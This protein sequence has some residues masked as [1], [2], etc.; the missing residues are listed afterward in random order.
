MKRKFLQ[1]Y[2]TRTNWNDTC[3]STTFLHNGL[4]FVWDEAQPEWFQLEHGAFDKV[5]E[6]DEIYLTSS[7][8]MSLKKAY[9]WAKM[10]PETKII[11]GGPVP[12]V[13]K[14]VSTEP[15]PSNL[16][17]TTA[18]AETLFDKKPNPLG[19]K[20]VPPGDVNGSY[21]YSYPYHTYCRWGQCRFCVEPKVRDREWSLE[22]LRNAPKGSVYLSC[23]SLGLSELEDIIHAD[24]DYEN[25]KYIFSIRADINLLA[26]LK[27]IPKPNRILLKVGVEFPSERMYAYMRKG[28]PIVEVVKF[29]N[30][31]AEMGYN[32]SLSF[33]T[34]WGILTPSVLDEAK[35]FFSQ[36][37]GHW[38]ANTASAASRFLAYPKLEDVDRSLYFDAPV[39]IGP[40]VVGHYL[41]QS[42]EQE[43]LNAEWIEILNDNGITRNPGKLP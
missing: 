4:H 19:F 32:V 17:F 22:P 29:I 38:M 18:L 5:P 6:A 27:R 12:R 25:R 35:V 37:R 2:N 1:F 13:H 20:L 40:F 43:K 11:V 9:E 3:N 39:T 42:V 8:M 16:I 36:I 34:H 33:I 14:I 24:L 26:A 21:T 31:T 41:K 7:A 30:E 10:S 15:L 23:L 28:I